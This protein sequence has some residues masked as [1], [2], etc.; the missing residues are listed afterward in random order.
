MEFTYCKTLYHLPREVLKDHAVSFIHLLAQ[1]LAELFC[2][3]T[4]DPTLQIRI[5]MRIVYSQ[6]QLGATECLTVDISETSGFLAAPILF[7]SR[8]PLSGP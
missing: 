6:C 1:H 5:R 7:G 8:L 3:Q 4:R 2:Q